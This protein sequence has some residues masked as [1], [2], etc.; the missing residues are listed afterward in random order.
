MVVSSCY[1]DVVVGSLC[2]SVSVYVC[3]CV[4]VCVFIHF[5]MCVFL[6]FWFCWCEIIYFLCFMGVVTLLRF[7]FPSS[8]FCWA[9]F[10]LIVTV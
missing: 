1:F 4:C 9:G 5:Y 3:V 8:T 10:F 2:V 7:E 6:F